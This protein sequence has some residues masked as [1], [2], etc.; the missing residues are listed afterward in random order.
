MIDPLSFGATQFITIFVP[1]FD[2][3]GA[4]GMSGEIACRIVNSV[5]GRP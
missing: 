3:V 5:D 1:L 4:I 2:V